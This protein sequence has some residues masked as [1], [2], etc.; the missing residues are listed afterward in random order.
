MGILYL[1]LSLNVWATPCQPTESQLALEFLKIRARLAIIA[2]KCP[3]QVQ[4]IEPEKFSHFLNRHKY[5]TLKG[6]S[7]AG[8]HIALIE[9]SKASP[10]ALGEQAYYRALNTEQERYQKETIDFYCQQSLSD[11]EQFT[12]LPREKLK[13][14]LE[15]ILCHPNLPYSKR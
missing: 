15:Q 9:K 10:R 2:A 12:N 14:H 11:F 8:Q 13:P 6:E 1:I 5:W 3:G 4:G 7:L